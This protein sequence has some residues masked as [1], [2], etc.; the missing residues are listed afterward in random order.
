[1]THPF[2]PLCGKTFE[3]LGRRE[4]WGEERVY[5]TDAD[6]RLRLFPATWTDAAAPDPF[7]VRAAGRCAFRAEDLVRLAG[8]VAALAPARCQGNDAVTGKVITPD[9]GA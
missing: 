6:G 2:H 9:G 4:A 8:L 3:Y 7:V 1:V 5:V